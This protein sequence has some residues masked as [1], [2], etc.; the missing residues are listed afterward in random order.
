MQAGE[1]SV[2]SCLPG[3]W[4]GML[5]RQQCRQQRAVRVARGQTAWTLS[6]LSH[7]DAMLENIPSSQR[8]RVRAEA[9]GI[10]GHGEDNKEV[11]AGWGSWGG[12]V[13]AGGVGLGK[14]M[15]WG[16]GVQVEGRWCSA[17]ECRKY[18]TMLQACHA[19][20]KVRVKYMRFSFEMKWPQPQPRWSHWRQVMRR[21]GED[22]P[23]PV[24]FWAAGK[25]G[26][27]NNWWN[28]CPCPA[29][30]FLLQEGQQEE[31]KA[32]PFLREREARKEEAEDEGWMVFGKWAF[33]GMFPMFL[34]GNFSEWMDYGYD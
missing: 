7:N 14:A 13:G 16:K 25:A 4:E 17:N 12:A 23:A 3:H 33:P 21:R 32:K 29:S 19:H 20:M 22:P 30:S 28:S 34:N 26:R 31:R 11:V 10:V 27:Q 18:I 8:V 5:Y 15:R 24:S 2:P 6:S 9:R 1:V